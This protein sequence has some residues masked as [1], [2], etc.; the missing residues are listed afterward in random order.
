[1]NLKSKR[2]SITGL[3]VA[4][5]IFGTIGI[6]RRYIDM[7]S[8]FIALCRAVIGTV[9]L[10]LVLVLT[11][12]KP[13]YSEIRKNL[14]LLILSSMSLGFNWIILFEAY[15]YTTVTTAT[16]C[17]YMAPSLIVL[18][19]HFFFHERITLKKGICVL[20]ALVGM[21]L[22]SGIIRTGIPSLSELKGILFGLGGA[23]LYATTVLL[24][25]KISL[26][27]PFDRTIIQLGLAGIILLPY[28]FLTEDFGS[29]S[30][31]A[32]AV[33]LLIVAGIVHTGIPYA[34]YFSTAKDLPSQT[35][36]LL[37]YLDPI[38]AISLSALILHEAIGVFEIFGAVLI[39][40]AAYISE[41]S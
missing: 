11:K 18:G 3:L 1:M 41:K 9:F 30:F 24:N 27:S 39:L 22:V 38:V 12:R 36:A 29:I 4:T 33:A 8:S 32:S 16:L 35:V 23:V 25:K 7:P 26:S 14:P 37:S 15:N 21:V 19:S 6:I 17:Y 40:G 31:T 13:D 10:A 20:V 2:S 5:V 28:T 34:L